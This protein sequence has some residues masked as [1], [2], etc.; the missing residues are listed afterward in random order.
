LREEVRGGKGKDP[1]KDP[2]K[3][4]DTFVVGTNIGEASACYL[5]RCRIGEKV[6]VWEF[7]PVQKRIL[8]AFFW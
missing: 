6:A 1:V 3:E 5:I 8:I 2:Q 4:W 7:V